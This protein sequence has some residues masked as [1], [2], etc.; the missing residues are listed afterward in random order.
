MNKKYL[1]HRIRSDTD[2]VLIHYGTKG[3]KW[4]IRRYQN[5]DGSL[6]SAGTRRYGTVENMDRTRS[7]NQRVAIGVGV[8]TAVVAGTIIARKNRSLKK[9]IRVNDAADAARKSKQKATNA[10]RAATIAK[11]KANGTWRTATK[12]SIPKGSDVKIT[13]YSSTLA[14]TPSNIVK[15]VSYYL[16]VFGGTLKP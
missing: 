3:Q 5:P 9:R 13:K 14:G 2:D 4:G 12:I 8:T 11:K 6:T 10:K 16:N 7:R 15:S 1:I